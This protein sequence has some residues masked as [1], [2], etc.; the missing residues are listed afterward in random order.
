MS[1][2]IHHRRSQSRRSHRRG[3]AAVE[4]AVVAPWIVL[5]VF[6]SIQV[7]QMI[8][9]SRTVCDASR[10]GARQAASPRVR[11][12]TEVRAAVDEYMANAYPGVSRQTLAAATQLTVRNT[13]GNEVPDGDLTLVTSGTSLSVEV[14]FDSSTVRWTSDRFNIYGNV[15]RTTSV[16]RRQ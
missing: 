1:K 7:G 9:I 15:L 10:E 12:V 8:H 16:M 3:A 14:R 6:G 13:L 4:C 5:I 2:M 11:T